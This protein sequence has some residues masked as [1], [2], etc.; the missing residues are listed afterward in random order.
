MIVKTKASSY[1]TMFE[2]EVVKSGDRQSTTELDM[3]KC[4]RVWLR[5]PHGVTDGIAHHWKNEDSDDKDDLPYV[6]LIK[7]E[8][9]V[10]CKKYPNG[11]F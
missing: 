1:A 5:V 10:L 6:L 3:Y 7:K 4:A 2:A 11:A 8:Y 9:Y